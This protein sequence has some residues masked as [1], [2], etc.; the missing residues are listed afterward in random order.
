MAI[1]VVHTTAVNNSSTTSITVTVPSTTAGNCLVVCLNAFTGGSTATISGIT[2]GGSAD[3]WAQATAITSFAEQTLIW[4]DPNCAGGQ[5]SIHISGSNLVVDSS[6][7]GIVI[8]EVSG[9]ALSAV[10]DQTHTGGANTGTAWS[11]GTTATTSQ[12]SE[13]AIGSVGSDPGILAMP[14][15][16]T[17]TINT[18]SFSGAGYKIL[19][20]TGT[21]VF[22]G[23]QSASNIWSAAIVTL[24]GTT[25][26]S[27]SLTTAQDNISAP[28]PTPSGTVSLTTAQ[29]NEAALPVTVGVVL[30]VALTVAQ[31]TVS[32]LPPGIQHGWTTALTTAQV[33]I[34]ALPVTP[35]ADIT[36]PLTTAQVNI[37]AHPPVLSRQL[38]ISLASKAGTDD[39]G[40]SILQGIQVTKGVISGTIFE[41]TDFIINTSGAFFYSSAP[42]SGN[43]IASIA[44]ASG[45]DGFGNSYN[46]GITSYVASGT[47]AGLAANIFEG[48]LSFSLPAI[49][50][51]PEYGTNFV[52]GASYEAAEAGMF[53]GLNSSTDKGVLIN[54][55]PNGSVGG[56]S[57]GSVTYPVVLITPFT[58]SGATG[59]VASVVAFNDTTLAPTVGISGA[60]LLYVANGHLYY[61]NPS[62]GVTELAT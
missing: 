49:Q 47:L 34:A 29:V 38:L 43:L 14:S 10:V 39:Y 56:G 6:N 59:S 9:L 26:V 42:A 58:T 3:N 22:N 24:K 20:T 48:L 35:G 53:S 1:S 52:T 57:P 25:D 31:E 55:I 54:L 50:Q 30:E 17:N 61:A 28:A 23:T 12:A 2:L 51:G 4:V 11:S 7:G 19:S 21:Q 15:G 37:A 41:G 33:N 8:Y 46:A 36:V 44:S 60:G 16:Y 45:T 18:G 32:A 5:T 62:G 13:I 27:V 40:N